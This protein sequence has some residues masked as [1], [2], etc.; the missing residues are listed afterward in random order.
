MIDF[1]TTDEDT[2]VIHDIAARAAELLEADLMTVS[3]DVTACHLNGCPLRL[4]DLLTADEGNFAHDIA[5]IARHLD[6]KSGEL[7]DC[8]L[9]RFAAS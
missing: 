5:G 6:R 8:F 7:Q 4:A 3:M 9:P 2:K 1:E